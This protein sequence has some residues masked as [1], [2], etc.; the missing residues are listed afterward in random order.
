MAVI[1]GDKVDGQ[2]Q[3]PKP[4][5]ATDAVE[6]R[7]GILGEVEVDH[8]VDRLDVDTAREQVCGGMNAQACRKRV[9]KKKMQ[10]K[11]TNKGANS[12]RVSY[13]RFGFLGGMRCSRF[14]PRVLKRMYQYGPGTN[15]AD[16]RFYFYI[17]RSMYSLLHLCEP[18]WVCFFFI[19]FT[20]LTLLSCSLLVV[21]QI[22]GHILGP[23]PA[24]PLRYAPSFLSR[25]EFSIFFPRRLASSCTYP[26]CY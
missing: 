26:R 1:V 17:F 12:Y 9:R 7:L 6:V 13:N 21:T 22:R 20:I 25:E 16:F 18:L 4:T 2:T 8:H 15:E 5:G 11:T 24:S 19:L 14:P 10:K 23:P 3:V